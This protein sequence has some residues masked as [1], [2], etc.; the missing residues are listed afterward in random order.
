M[1]DCQDFSPTVALLGA[2]RVPRAR[3][4]QELEVATAEPG[5]PPGRWTTLATPSPTGSAA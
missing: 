2:E 3:F 4:L 1:I 5:L